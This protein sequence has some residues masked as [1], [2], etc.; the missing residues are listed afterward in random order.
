MIM[1]RIECNFRGVIKR[2]FEPVR[3]NCGL[4]GRR[5][6][7]EGRKEGREKELS[8]N[9]RHGTGQKKEAKKQKKASRVRLGGCCKCECVCVYLV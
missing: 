6:R 9:G 2:K 5:G 8:V 4:R 7:E 3:E 1:L